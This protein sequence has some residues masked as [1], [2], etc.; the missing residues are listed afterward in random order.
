MLIAGPLHSKY[1][2]RGT[3]LPKFKLSSPLR[4]RVPRSSS[5]TIDNIRL[6]GRR[7]ST[8]VVI[9]AFSALATADPPR[10]FAGCA[11]LQG[12]NTSVKRRIRF[13]SATMLSRESG[14]ERLCN[15]HTKKGH[16]P[17]VNLRSMPPGPVAITVPSLTVGALPSCAV[18]T[19]LQSSIS[20]PSRGG[21]DT[22]RLTG[23]TIFL[24]GRRYRVPTSELSEGTS[25]EPKSV[26]TSVTRDFQ[27]VHVANMC[28]S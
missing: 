17:V 10:L 18:G 1:I 13:W 27:R 26:R 2:F 6:S 7:D 16:R 11:R 24:G 12:C 14:A 28:A 23:M 15:S 9:S 19:V 20:A 3:F 22:P 21:R 4:T 25:S 8:L 5:D